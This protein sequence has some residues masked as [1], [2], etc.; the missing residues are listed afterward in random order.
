MPA[1]FYLSLLSLIFSA[2]I[3]SISC[4]MSLL[5]FYLSFHDNVVIV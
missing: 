5:D 1:S 2:L 3:P 4:N